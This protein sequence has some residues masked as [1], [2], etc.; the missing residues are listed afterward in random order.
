MSSS[1]VDVVI[2]T[3][4]DGDILDG[5][6]QSALH[7]GIEDLSLIVVDNGSDPPAHVAGTAQLLYNAE[8]RGVAAG[9]NQGVRAGSAPYVCLLDSDARL[10]PGALVSML[11]VL[12]DNGDV[13]MV[14]PVFKGQAPSASA[15][16]VYGVLYKALRALN[17]RNTYAAGADFEDGRRD[18]DFAIGACQLFRRSVFDAVGGL[19]E[20]YFYGPEDVDFCLR[21]REHGW[22]IVQ[23]HDAEVEHP[24][25][26][27]NRRILSRSGAMHASAVLRHFWRH[28]HFRVLRGPSPRTHRSPR[29]R[30]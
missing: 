23:L 25:R 6:V 29:E 2:L 27:R 7:S 10:L 19:D 28:R 17:V 11:Q 24:P 9:R 16:P 3:W 26:R 21:L 15:G 30:S 22:R 5:A 20:S 1:R 18:V 8:N 14:V 12:E 4:N 13:A